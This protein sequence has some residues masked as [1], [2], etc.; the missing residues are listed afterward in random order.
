MIAE[1]PV[2]EGFAGEVETRSGQNAFLCYQCKKCTSGCPIADQMDY[3]P[4]QILRMV[5]M[6]QRD[7]VLHSKTIWLCASC[8]TCSTRCPQGIDV[9][10]IMDTMKSISYAEGIKSPIPSVEIFNKVFLR[11][12]KMT[13]RSYEIGLLGE[14]KMR[15]M[16]KGKLDPDQFMKDAI[17][18]F[19]LFT[20]GKLPVLPPVHLPGRKGESHRPKTGKSVAYYPGCSLHSSGKEFDLSTRAVCEKLGLNLVEPEGWG[21]CGASSAHV[22]SH[23]LATVL[24]VKNLSLV[25]KAGFDEV[26]VPCAACFSRLKAAV[27]DMSLDPELRSEVGRDVGYDYK[28]TVKIR[29]LLDTLT[30]NVGLEKIRGRVTRSL[31]GLK[32]VC[33]YGCLLTRPPDITEALHPEYPIHMDRLMEA[34]GAQSLDWSYKTDCCGASFALTEP[35][36]VMRLAQRILQNAKDVGADAV[37]VACPLCHA[38]LDTRQ[39]Q[40]AEL[41]GQRYDLPIFYFTELMG[42]AMGVEAKKLGAQKHVQDPLPLLRAKGLASI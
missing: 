1:T 14:L 39:G 29:H 27:H 16:A 35:D 15:L 10:R 18:G 3:T 9:V 22:V 41:Y 34:L 21:C 28:G 5:Q 12:V 11:W 6:G 8:Q 20:A 40:I 42:L 4:N 19:K 2:A 38:N 30:E 25:E 32:V 24:P 26:A 36:V 37:V 7:K 23:E 33:Y 17:L 31:K 13:G